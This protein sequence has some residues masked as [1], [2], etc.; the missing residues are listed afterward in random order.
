MLHHADR[1]QV[2][3]LLA[4]IWVV[5]LVVLHI[6][7]AKAS[8][9]S[10]LGHV[11]LNKAVLEQGG[12]PFFCLGR[13]VQLETD[14]QGRAH[15]AEQ[16][17][18]SRFFFQR[19]LKVQQ[20]NT[21]PY[22]ALAR[23]ALMEDKNEEA[24]ELLERGSAL[25]INDLFIY[26][27]LGCLY[28]STGRLQEAV[29]L[30]HGIGAS[31]FFI[32]RGDLSYSARNFVEAERY[33][34]IAIDLG[35]TQGKIFYRVGEIRRENSDY[36]SALGFYIEGIERDPGYS[37]W[38]YI[39]VGDYYR[40]NNRFED[41]AT[42][43]Q[44]AA[45]A[46][47]RSELPIMG[48]ALNE[49]AQEHLASALEYIEQAIFLNSRSDSA[50]YLRGLIYYEQRKFL[51]AVASFQEALAIA[52]CTSAY[53]HSLGDAYQRLG[54]TFEADMAYR[55]AAVGPERCRR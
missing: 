50:Y 46:F 42:W 24:S 13:P 31:Q 52:P 33:Y 47:P 55:N 6:P 21:H 39:R 53:W 51:D 27:D 16:A 26:F 10:N 41:A 15:S 23:L 19:A 3:P 44:R 1:R 37:V 28:A 32:T 8:L 22:R 5:L 29:S 43:Y 12:K 14:V 34:R 54:Q 7:S 17:R 4:A 30:W 20:Y 18:R 11:Y 9:W 2:I 25:G 38:P 49:S 45:R 48:L 35:T 36:F 40:Y